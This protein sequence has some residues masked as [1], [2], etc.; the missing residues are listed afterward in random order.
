VSGRV[1]IGMDVLNRIVGGGT[2][3]IKRLLLI[4]DD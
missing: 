2:T 4:S 3:I 1:D